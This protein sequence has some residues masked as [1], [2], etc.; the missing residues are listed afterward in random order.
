MRYEVTRE[1]D[2]FKVVVIPSDEVPDGA[3]ELLYAVTEVVF[4][5]GRNPI[6]ICGPGCG[7]LSLPD[8]YALARHVIDTPLRHCKIAFVY[9]ADRELESSRFI[10][11]LGAERGLSL[12]VFP[13]E[14][15]A[16]QWATGKRTKE[17]D[18]ES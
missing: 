14:G 18:A 13:T 16:I 11:E 5:H 2:Y 15:D 1:R 17:I 6:L 3:R 7:P 12:N 8:L 4:K 10:D 9:Q